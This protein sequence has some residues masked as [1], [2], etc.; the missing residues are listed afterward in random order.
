MMKKE[1]TCGKTTIT[2]EEIYYLGYDPSSISD[3]VMQ[4]IADI[5][6]QKMIQAEGLNYPWSESVLGEWYY[7]LCEELK[8]FDVPLI[9]T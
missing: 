5:V 4:R 6:E 7:I 2:R 1:F 9:M 8:A 3:E